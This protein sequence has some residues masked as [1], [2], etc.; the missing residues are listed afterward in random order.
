MT[1]KHAYHDFFP[2]PSVRAGQEEMMAGIENAVRDGT[3]ICAEAPNGF[4]KTCAT[5]SG[6]LPW[7]RETNGKILYCA[8][9]HRQ[10]DRVVEELDVILEKTDVSGVSFRGRRHMC[11]N[12]FVLENADFVAPISE[13][14]GQLKATRRCVYY[15]NLRVAG[16]PQDLLEDMPSPVLTAPDIVKIGRS[17]SICPYELAKRL[18]KV[19]DVVALSYLYV[20]DPWIL[21][22]FMPELET[23]MSK[24]VLVQD[25]AHN[26][27]STAL[28]SASDSLT[29]GAIRQ[30]MREATTYNDSISKEF[31][32]GLAK[33]ILD[34]TV[35]MAETGEKVIEAQ[36]LF[37]LA[38]Q[39]S[40]L[41]PETDVLRHM[42]DF[43]LNIRKS[44]LKAGKFPRSFIHRV[45]DFMIRWLNNIGRDDYSFIL[46]SSRGRGESKRV[47]LELNALDPTAVTGPVLSLVHSSVAVSGT[48]SPL[49]AYSEM[50]GFGP[51]AITNVY[52][53][54]FATRNRLCLVV[55]GVETTYQARNDDMF[56]RMVNHCVA[57][58]HAT[59]GNTGIFTTSYSIGK[60]LLKAGLEKRLKVRL[61]QE[62]PGMKGTENDNM[63]EEFKRRG[64]KGG[65]VLLGVQGG[66]NSEGGD[67]P[68]P[69]M[70]SAIVVGVPYARP[71]P[72]TES[73]IGYY[74]ERFENK[75][76][77]YAY[78]LPAMTR[79]IQAAGRPV[80]KLDDKGAI[81]LLDQRFA[82]PY[83][84]RFLPSWLAEV[85]QVIQDNPSIA[86]EQVDAFFADH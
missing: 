2:Y 37:D 42:R 49:D 1:E 62:K 38:F 27:P 76:R 73:L 21:E 45:A 40:G 53:S 55:E 81:V 34:Q 17:R 84:K 77:E 11:I 57:V 59:P 75:G 15:E 69:T 80:R 22:A 66:R 43:G 86:A 20:F 35:G 24:M 51:K 50:L 30:A 39:I 72:S 79:A 83:L 52:H 60:S 29:I 8:R 85:T 4:G 9:T 47:S 58:A 7:V 78:V 3:H 68:G 6:V 48:L 61:F 71:T 14:C 67:F 36:A 31:S 65:A 12:Q 74:D 82:S 16:S 23:P 44:L 28:S 10:L 41:D 64:E 19:V 56:K 5:L 33:C 54:P 18:A 13:V 32:R 46:A 25:E 70:E 26:V 63:I